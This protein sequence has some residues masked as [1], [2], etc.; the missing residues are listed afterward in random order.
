[1][2]FTTS[3]AP[4]PDPT[5]TILTSLPRNLH[6]RLT[7]QQLRV[8]TV[9]WS[10]LPVSLQAWWWSCCWG[11]APWDSSKRRRWTHLHS[12]ERPHPRCCLVA[13]CSFPHQ[14]DIAG[15]PASSAVHE[16]SADLSPAEGEPSLTEK[17]KRGYCFSADNRCHF[18]TNPSIN[19]SKASKHTHTH[20]YSVTWTLPT[21]DQ[22]SNE[23]T[24]TCN[25]VCVL[26]EVRFTEVFKGHIEYV[27]I[28]W[29]NCIEFSTHTRTH[30]YIHSLLH[31]DWWWQCEQ[32][33]AQQCLPCCHCN[34]IT[35]HYES[36]CRRTAT[37][38]W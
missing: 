26:L 33:S 32:M 24:C 35:V 18:Y 30:T 25:L 4:R 8:V 27:Y 11:R 17:I 7:T 12:I 14:R 3:P 34:S 5:P 22:H 19:D 28:D 13:A 38:M 6:C 23:T 10:L 1:M 31:C 16:V 9:Q 37:H 20:I 2:I 29:S 21:M 15:P 36:L